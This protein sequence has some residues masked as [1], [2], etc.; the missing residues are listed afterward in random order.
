MHKSEGPGE[1]CV[2]QRFSGYKRIV[3]KLEYFTSSLCIKIIAISRPVLVPNT[4][5]MYY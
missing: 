5:H 2:N 4:L 1:L 3:R